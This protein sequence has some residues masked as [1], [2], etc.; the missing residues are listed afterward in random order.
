MKKR[1]LSGLLCAVLLLGLVPAGL[2]ATGVSEAEAARTLAALDIMSGDEKGDLALSRPLTRGEFTKLAVGASVYADSMGA[3]AAVAPYPDVPKSHWAAPAVQTAKE[4]GLVKGNLSGYFEP[5]RTVTLVE[6]AALALRLLGYEDSDFTGTW[7]SGQM[8]KYR[9]LGLDRNITLGENDP[10]TRRS[11]LWLFYNLLTAKNK[12]GQTYLTTLGH[13]LTPGGEIDMVALVNAAMEGPIVAE[14]DWRAALP[15]TVSFETVFRSGSTSSQAAIQE[16]DV[17]YYSEPLRT[18]WV[19]T[20]KA[21]GSIQSLSPSATN[22]TAVAV[23]GKTYAIETATAAYDL[24]DLGGFHT[25]DAV[26]LLLGRGGGVAAVRGGGQSAASTVYGVVTATGTGTYQ[27]ADG[28]RYTAPNVTLTATDGGSYTYRMENEKKNFEPGN[29]VRVSLSGKETVLTRLT[30]TGLTG[31]VSADADSLGKHPFAPEVEI[32]DTFGKTTTGRVYPTRLAGVELKGDMVRYY[33]L[34]GRGEITHLILKDATGDLH[35]YG[36][37]N[38]IEYN[39]TPLPGSTGAS[40]TYLYDLAGVP[41]SY[42]STKTFW[43]V[44]EGPSQFKTEGGKVERIE[45]L[46]ELKLSHV[47]G[48]KALAGN[49]T[50]AV[51]DDVAVYELREDTYY[52]TDLD[53]VGGEGYTLTGWYDKSEA[54]GGRVRVI[55][56]EAN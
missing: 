31:K 45:N 19:Y 38:K 7:G 33:A 48:G 3:T 47:E 53:R 1:L 49:Q 13:T 26:T 44:E 29:L 42:T 9:T 25:G 50:W 41:G 36:I 12:A 21:T 24:S 55:L 52:L 28:K 11:A 18:L 8:A 15:K 6:G 16:N 35:G 40:T 43:S 30:E 10:M 14:G 27:D 23:G 51:A 39:E 34:N 46:K 22:P 20:G 32:L 5:G 4:K 56:A 37:L 17:I 2:A 54:D